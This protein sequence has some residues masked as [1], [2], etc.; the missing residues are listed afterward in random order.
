MSNHFSPKNML[1]TNLLA[2]IAIF[3]F[4]GN[5]YAF[6]GNTLDSYGTFGIWRVDLH[7]KINAEGLNVNLKDELNISSQSSLFAEAEMRFAT[8]WKLGLAYNGLKHEGNVVKTVTLN[9]INFQA[10]ARLT[11]KISLFEFGFYRDIWEDKYQD[12]DLGIG[13]KIARTHVEVAGSESTTG[14]SR[15]ETYD[16]TL[17]IPHIA[18]AYR[19]RLNDQLWSVSTAKIFSLNRSEGQLTVTD[20]NTGLAFEFNQGEERPDY[21]TEWSLGIGYRAFTIDG[22][23]DNN[24]LELGY[25]GF[26]AAAL[27]RF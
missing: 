17:P 24:R 20:F 1:I 27:A 3:L 11:M 4:A 12:I 9:N 15:S 8:H 26:W 2:I 16:E 6:S 25:R 5:A 23:V 21:K 22:K 19:R 14:I 18:V 13:A 7:G 10:Q